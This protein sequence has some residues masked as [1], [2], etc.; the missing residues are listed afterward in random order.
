MPLGSPCFFQRRYLSHDPIV[1][2]FQIKEHV[3]DRRLDR[4]GRQPTSGFCD[5]AFE[6]FEPSLEFRERFHAFFLSLSIGFWL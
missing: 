5:L 4:M 1:F 6:F 2:I 3:H